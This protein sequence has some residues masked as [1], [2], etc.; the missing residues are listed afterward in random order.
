[1]IITYM[2]MMMIIIILDPMT[3]KQS[4]SIPPDCSSQRWPRVATSHTHTNTCM[5]PPARSATKQ[6]QSQLACVW[7]L[8]CACRHINV[9]AALRSMNVSCK[10]N[11]SRAQRHLYLNDMVWRAMT[12]A[13]IPAVKEP[14]GLVRSDGNLSVLTASHQPHGT[15][16]LERGPNFQ[17]A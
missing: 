13:N 6:C 14:H 8:A 15:K 5:R 16:A 4:H 10:G 3:P 11:T 9:R 7:A 12:R 2:M 1:M 17:Q